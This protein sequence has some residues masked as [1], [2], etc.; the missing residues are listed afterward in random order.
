MPDNFVKHLVLP[1]MSTDDTTW[2]TYLSEDLSI[3][4]KTYLINPNKSKT[5]PGTLTVPINKLNPAAL[6][7]LILGKLTKLQG[8]RG[9]GISNLL[10]IIEHY[11][12]LPDIAIFTHAHSTAWH[13]NDLQLSSTPV[14]LL[15]LNYR[16]IMEH[17][18][19]NLRYH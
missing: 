13:N 8:P 10:Y 1:R 16:R 15:E 5:A 9:A 6:H 12:N 4:T 18:Y 11:D 17:G 14:M 7:V 2:H 3:V 19:M